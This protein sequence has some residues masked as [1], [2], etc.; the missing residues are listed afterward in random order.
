MNPTNLFLET[1]LWWLVENEKLADTT[2]GG[3]EDLLYQQNKI[4]KKL[5]NNLIKSL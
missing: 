5:Y 1:W 4:I 2:K 3:E